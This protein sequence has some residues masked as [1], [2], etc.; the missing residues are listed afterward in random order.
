M[1]LLDQLIIV[2][3]CQNDI[4]FV[5]HGY[6]QLL[7]KIVLKRSDLSVSSS[8]D[9]IPTEILCLERHKITSDD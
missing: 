7:K 9:P 6:L 2:Q 4:V 8:P 3:F 1:H 5:S